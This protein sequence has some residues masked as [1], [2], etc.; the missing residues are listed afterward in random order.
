MTIRLFTLLIL[1]VSTPTWAAT[2]FVQGKGSNSGAAGTTIAVTYDSNIT[3]GNLIVLAVA[4]NDTTSTA[5]CADGAGNT[6][7]G[8]PV[9]TD[10]TNL[11]RIQAFYALNVTGG[12]LTTTCTI[13]SSVSR[14][15]LIVHEVSGAATASALDVAAGQAQQN[16]TTATDN[17]TSGAATTTQ[18]GDYIFGASADMNLACNTTLPGTGFTDRTYSGCGGIPVISESQIQSAAGSIAATF[19]CS[20]GCG[21]TDDWSTVMMTFKE[22]TSAARRGLLL[23][24]LP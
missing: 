19:T 1:L 8:G 6:Y 17:I 22:Q 2:A 11:R 16:V 24:V 4:W 5:S 10:A 15:G 20:T 9:I 21:G 13:S 3:A 14:R 12:A 18:N 7:T 23:G